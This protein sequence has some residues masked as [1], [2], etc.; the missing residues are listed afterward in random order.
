ML[1]SN[2]LSRQDYALI[3]LLFLTELTRSAFFLTFWPLYAVNFLNFS[4]VNAGVVLSA[5]YF[6]ETLFKA[7]A[8]CQ[9]DRRGKPVLLMGLSLSLLSLLGIYH[10]QANW[11]ILVLAG[12]FGLG[13]APVWLAVISTVAPTDHPNRAARMGVV[14]S[15]WL[16]GA[17]AGPVGINF[18]IS[19]G[20]RPA[21]QLLIVFWALCLVIG[22]LIP[23]RAKT[24]C[25]RI[26]L[27]DQFKRLATDPMVIKILLPGMFLQTLAASLLLPI[28]FICHRHP[29]INLPAV[30]FVING[31]GAATVLFLV[32]M[33]KL[34]DRLPLKKVLTAG[35]LL[36][37]LFLSL[38]P[39]TRE[40]PVIIT[41][42]I[43]VGLSYAIVLPAWNSLLARVIPAEHQ[44]TG[45]GIFTTLEGLGIATGPMLGGVISGWLHPVGAIYLSAFILAGMGFFYL[46]YPFDQTLLNQ[47]R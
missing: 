18:V 14:F 45:W 32:P 44:A 34:V 30:R 40:L 15:A 6:T 27:P 35:F 5:H 7:A 25:I 28:L 33:G 13:F 46:F 2:R 8:G 10:Q 29:G 12:L 41:L 11:V 37:A 4:V 9:L 42:V 19:A 1:N 39:L 17:G 20:F 31:R 3:L 23:L 22:L 26:S 16:L 21:F 38:F 43:L 47:G 36:S 24:G